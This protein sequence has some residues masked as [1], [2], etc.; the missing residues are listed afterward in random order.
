MTLMP[1]LRHLRVQEGGNIDGSRMSAIIMDNDSH[2]K[3]AASSIDSSEKKNKPITTTTN[4]NEIPSFEKDAEPTGNTSVESMLREQ[5][6]ELRKKN[7]VLETLAKK[8][9]P[10]DIVDKDSSAASSS[11]SG[12]WWKG[13]VPAAI[14]GKREGD[15][16]FTCAIM[17]DN[18]GPVKLSYKNGEEIIEA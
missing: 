8:R 9:F 5:I 16:T 10:I 11:S 17:P 7:E 1:W 12:E 4:N 3:A 18:N 13:I 6:Q 15:D 14:L 2:N